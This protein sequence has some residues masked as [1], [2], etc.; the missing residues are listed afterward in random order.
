MG[1]SVSCFRIS[2]VDHLPS[3]SQHVWLLPSHHLP[4]TP[5]LEIGTINTISAI[6]TTTGQLSER[7]R[8][9]LCVRCGQ[10]GHWVKDYQMSACPSSPRRISISAVSS[11]RLRSRSRI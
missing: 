1:Y 2:I 8:A 9:G 3:R 5:S 4:G 10:P 7:R 11:S 6:S